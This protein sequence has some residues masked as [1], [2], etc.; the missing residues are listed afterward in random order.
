MIVHTV[1]TERTS[2]EHPEEAPVDRY[3]RWNALLEL[4]TDSGRVTV[5]QTLR[6]FNGKY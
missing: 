6:I 3:A 5:D 2:H 4:L 1:V